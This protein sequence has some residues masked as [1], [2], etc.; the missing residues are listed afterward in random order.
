MLQVVFLQ[1]MHDVVDSDTADQQRQGEDEGVFE[2]GRVRVERSLRV[3]EQHGDLRATIWNTHGL[4]VDLTSSPLGKDMRN[5]S[6]HMIIPVVCRPAPPRQSNPF[7]GSFSFPIHSFRS[8]ND[9]RS[10]SL[11]SSRPRLLSL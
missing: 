5:G 11:P 2:H 6:L 9:P 4:R 3:H 7:S 10:P 8:W 1:V